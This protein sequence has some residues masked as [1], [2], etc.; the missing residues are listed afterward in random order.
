MSNNMIVIGGDLPVHRLGYG[1]LRL[2]PGPADRANSIAVARRAVELGVRLIDTADAYYLGQNEELLAEALHPY[3]ADLVIATKGGQVHPGNDW[4]PLGR[5]EYLRQQTE[6]SLRR[7]RVD[8]I[9]LYQLH[10]IDPTVAFE[11]QIGALKRLRDDG[12]VR[13]VGLSEVSVDELVLASRIVPIV[14]VQNLYNLTDRG[15]EDV[16]EHCEREGIA[17]LPWLPVKPS[18]AAGGNDPLARIAARLGASPAQVAL[19]W[20]LQ[21][22]PVMLPIPGTSSLAH[23]AENV[24]AAGFELSTEDIRVLDA[25]VASAV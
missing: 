19:A 25:P 11:D 9:D 12:K 22:S 2:R 21:R 3:P 10:R 4:I 24:A 7:L 13:H 20:L 6:L 16:L 18:T 23:L 15:A 17:F 14:S 1:A 8:T 5:P